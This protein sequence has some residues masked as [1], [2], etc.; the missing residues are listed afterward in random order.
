[1]PKKAIFISYSRKDKRWLDELRTMLAPLSWE[2][3]WS[4]RTAPHR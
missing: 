1:V 4:N 3:S 2:A